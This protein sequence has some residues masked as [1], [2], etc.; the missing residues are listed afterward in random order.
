[1]INSSAGSS[2]ST[3]TSTSTSSSHPGLWLR[4]TNKM[5]RVRVARA[6]DRK[7][8]QESLGTS[9]KQVVFRRASKSKALTPDQS[10][11]TYHLHRRINQG[12]WSG[13]R[14]HLDRVILSLDDLM[15]QHKELQLVAWDGR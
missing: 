14:Q 13:V 1:M 7:S 10:F 2:V 6:A 9:V 12:S 15:S 3:S 4:H 8:T 5:E 11:S